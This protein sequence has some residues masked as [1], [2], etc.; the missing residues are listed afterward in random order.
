MDGQEFVVLDLLDSRHALVESTSTF[1]KDKVDASKLILADLDGANSNR[2]LLNINDSQWVKALEIFK[3]IESLVYTGKKNRTRKQVEKV[4]SASNTHP[5]TVY[6]WLSKYE[7]TGLISSLVRS[8]RNDKGKP[9]LKPEVEDVIQE[10][11]EGYYLKKQKPSRAAAFRDVKRKC[12]YRGLPVPDS[13]TV[14]NRI[15]DIDEEKRVSRREGYK[16]AKEQYEPIQGKFPGA[17]W[18]LAVVQID[19]TPMDVIV[20]DD[21]HRLPINRPYLTLATDVFS[22]DVVGFYISLD[23]PSALSV[24]ICI[25]HAILTKDSYLAGLGVDLPWPCWGVMRTVHVDNAAE[26]RGEMLGKACDDYGIVLE[27]RKKGAPNYGGHVERLF[28]TFMKNIHDELPGTTFSN[29]AEKGEY[30]STGCA[31][32]TMG[33]LEKWFTLFIVGVY[34]QSPHSGIDDLPPAVKWD[35]GIYGIPD[36]QLGTGIPARVPNEQRLRLDFLPFFERTIQRY[37]I[38]NK[39]ITYWSDALRHLVLAKDPKHPTRLRKFICRYDPRNLS[40]LW[41][42][43]SDEEGYIEVP[44]RDLTRP[45][46]SEWELREAQRRLKKR[47]LDVTNEELIFK[48]IGEMRE[49]VEEEARKTKSAR[50]SQQRRKQWNKGTATTHPSS[51]PPVGSVNQPEQPEDEGNDEMGEIVPFEDIQEPESI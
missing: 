46:I 10:V 22:R 33:A 8:G 9:R 7:K 5:S 27:H 20:V 1:E 31:I 2:D 21:V 19:H 15:F 43:I 32:M 36:G 34:H 48:T 17:D 39:G 41:V 12:V 42:F 45:P 24:G 51:K 30:D 38:V 28:R 40:R 4:A 3:I 13:K 37:G 6:R 18:P 26:F 11:I 35:E 44:Y 50:R 47:S 16:K 29:I 23:P 49:I 25:S 14:R